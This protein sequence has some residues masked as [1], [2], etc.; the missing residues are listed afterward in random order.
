MNKKKL[1]IFF[2]TLLALAG[3]TAI[4]ST[5]AGGAGSQD[6]PLVTLSYL[7][8]TFTGQVMDKVDGLIAARNAQLAE[9][10]G[11]GGAA[12][13]YTA[14]TLSAGQ[15]LTGKAGCEVLLRSGGARCTASSTPGL[16]DATSG[17]VVNGGASLQRNHLYLMTDERGVASSDGAVLLVRGSFTIQ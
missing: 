13:S 9:E 8:E 6:D 12:A 14:V 11:G 1:R 16:V 15:T 7:T 2:C 17:G 5:A 3:L 4:A 10:L